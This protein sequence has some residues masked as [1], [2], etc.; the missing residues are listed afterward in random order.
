M[1]L[2]SSF[3]VLFVVLSSFFFGEAHA[4]R[5]EKRKDCPTLYEEI[6]ASL[7]ELAEEGSC[8]WDFLKTSYCIASPSP[9]VLEPQKIEEIIQV[10]EYLRQEAL[11][12]PEYVT[13]AQPPD[14]GKSSQNDT[15]STPAV[16]S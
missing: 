16:A 10:T 11:D 5:L 13:Q 9:D 1:P 2:L 4:V 15:S 6:I 12:S 7:P 14:F 8:M 3:L